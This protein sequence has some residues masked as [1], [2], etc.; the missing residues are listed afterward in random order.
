MIN[1]AG[2]FSHFNELLIITM[3]Q[4]LKGISVFDCLGDHP[5]N[6]GRVNHLYSSPFSE[7]IVNLWNSRKVGVFLTLSNHYIDF[8]KEPVEE[9]SILNRSPLNGV[10]VSNHSLAMLIRKKYP[11]LKLM[12]SVTYFD[13]LKIPF[14]LK[15][16]EEMYDIICPRYEW[17][18]N[19]EF[20]QQA[21]LSKYEVMLND[22]C[23][24]NCGLW[25]KHFDA[26]NRANYSG[27][28]DIAKL[29]SIQECWLTNGNPRDGW[30]SDV[31]KYG[32]A[33]GMDLS[34]NQIKKA[35]K[36]GYRNWK[37]S[38]R[39]FSKAEYIEEISEFLTGL[40]MAGA[41]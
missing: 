34:P 16:L 22:T 39:E 19:P 40:K 17:V 38:G 37:I 15:Q 35:L 26:I 33:L 36:I 9:L 7:D 32:D 31:E 12:L 3:K 10:I 21:E 6:G 18:F 27:E 4:K 1:I 24:Y 41:A 2:A 28:T 5:W 25:S 11:N 29:H 20:Y 8:S 30:Q 13:S 14:N 23:K